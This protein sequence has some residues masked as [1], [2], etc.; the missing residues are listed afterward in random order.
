MWELVLFT[1]FPEN[2]QVKRIEAQS[3]YIF[4]STPKTDTIPAL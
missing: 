2:F 1:N 3:L 4:N